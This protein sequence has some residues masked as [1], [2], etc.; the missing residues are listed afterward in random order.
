M[1]YYLEGFWK[2]GWAIAIHTEK[3]IPL[4]DGGF[5]TTY[6][7]IGKQL[8]KLKYHSDYSQLEPLAQTVISF[9]K[10]RLVTPYLSAIIPTPSSATR[11]VQP[12]LEI[13]KRV[14]QGLN[15]PIDNKYLLKTRNTSQL[16]NIVDQVERQKILQGAFDIVDMR[17]Q[18]KKVLLFDDLFRSGSTLNEI[19]KL[20]Y[21]KGKVQDVYV[22]TL[23]KTRVKR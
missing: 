20:L 18:N 11:T 13:A 16:K 17:Y 8:N 9:L 19:S 7:P 6:T 15:I 1:S 2:A 21:R 14:S 4:P 12:V 10:T 22:V 3:S 5:D 23:T